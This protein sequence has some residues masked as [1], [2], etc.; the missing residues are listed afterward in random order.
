VEGRIQALARVHSLLSESR[1][2]GASIAQLVREELAPYRTGNPDRVR[3][4][5]TNLSLVAPAAQ[6]LALVLHELATNAAK[7]GSLSRQTGNVRV[8]WELH[9]E[10]LDIRWKESGGPAIG[11]STAGKFGI[12]VVKASIESQLG[13]TVDFDWSPKGLSCE[14]S[15]PH[16]GT[17]ERPGKED[18]LSLVSRPADTE[19]VKVGLRRRVLLVEDESLIGMM[20]TQTLVELG[21]EVLG[22]FAKVSEALKAIERQPVDAGILDINLGGEN[23]YPVARVL[24]SL[25]VPFVFMTG[26]GSDAISVPYPDARIFQKPVSRELLKSL[27]LPNVEQEGP[28]EDSGLPLAADARSA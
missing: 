19:P 14:I 6:A 27:F 18:P 7:Y 12:R 26:Y 13:G 3:I 24:R 1:W 25:K 16:E 8:G 28:S 15:I 21:Y 23:A 4:S 10:K 22:P 9:G 2:R 11:G 17:L 20:M 5:G